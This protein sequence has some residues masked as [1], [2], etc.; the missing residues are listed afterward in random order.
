MPKKNKVEQTG[1][2]F[3]I[4]PQDYITGASPLVF[5]DINPSGDWTKYIPKEEKQYVYAIFDTFSCTTFSALNKIEIA[6]NYLIKEKKL[7]DEIR[8]RLNELGF[9]ADG[10]FNA[11]DRFTATMSGTMPNGNYFQNVWDSIRKDGILPEVLLPFGGNNQLEYLNKNLIT[12]EMRAVALEFTK[13]FD[14]GYEWLSDTKTL[15]KELR[16]CA[17]QIAIPEIGSHAVVAITKNTHFDSYDPFIKTNP[18][19][20]YGMKSFIRP[21]ALNA[22]YQ[23]TTLMK[24]G[25]RTPE[26]LQ[27]QK[28]LKDEGFY[29]YRSI[30]GFFGSITDKAVK[31]YQKANGLRPDGIVGPK[32]H[33]VLNLKKKVQNSFNLDKFDLIPEIETKAITFLTMANNASYKLRI[34]SGRR[35][36]EEQNTKFEQGRTD[37]TK[38]IV[39]WTRNSKHIGGRAFDIAF[40]GRNPYPANFDWE[41][42]G[43]M[44]ELCGLKWGGR[45]RKNKDN[46][47]FEI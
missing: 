22:T 39:T 37:K 21:K 34:T 14:I 42:L 5:E 27:L 25:M 15:D 44:G 10:S 23:F 4:T 19:I 28:R 40:T 24:I 38:P 18:A 26:V 8:T 30:T 33:A 12:P 17:I 45:W 35:T 1:F 20:A 46:L 13:L 7:P 3:K 11:S 41:I 6:I 32:T 47:H 9:F 43:K 36:Q 29:T 16:Q 31:A 2:L